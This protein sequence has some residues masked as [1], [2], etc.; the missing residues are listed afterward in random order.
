MLHERIIYTAFAVALIVI[1][2]VLYAIIKR[3]KK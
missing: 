3:K 1:F 2:F